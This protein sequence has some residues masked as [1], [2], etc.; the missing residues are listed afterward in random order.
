MPEV[1]Y[2]WAMDIFLFLSFESL[3]IFI[4]KL[5]HKEKKNP[6][7]LEMPYLHVLSQ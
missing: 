3:V 5:F 1:S 2:V 6:D 4:Q 7:T